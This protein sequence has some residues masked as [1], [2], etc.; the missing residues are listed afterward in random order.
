MK[1]FMT[2]HLMAGRASLLTLLLSHVALLLDSLGLCGVAR[3]QTYSDTGYQALSVTFMTYHRLSQRLYMTGLKG[4]SWSWHSYTEE[5]PELDGALSVI[6]GLLFPA[7]GPAFEAFL[8]ISIFFLWE[9]T[10]NSVPSRFSQPLLSSPGPQVCSVSYSPH[11]FW[12][13]WLMPQ[14]V[15]CGEWAGWRSGSLTLF[16]WGPSQELTPYLTLSPRLLALTN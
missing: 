8:S 5:V 12:A 14:T 11:W 3:S 9:R 10:E 7:Q 2:T 16:F 1:N 15:S 4:K 13:T 6:M